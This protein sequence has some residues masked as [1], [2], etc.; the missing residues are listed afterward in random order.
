MTDSMLEEIT[1]GLCT[2]HGYAGDELTAAATAARAGE[3]PMLRDGANTSQ[4]VLELRVHGVGGAP[5]TEN[6]EAPAC[7]QVAGDRSAG[8]YRAWYPGR[9]V[10]KAAPRRE[11]Y[12][13]GKLNYQAATRALWLL[14]L[15]FA[16]LNVAHWA[17]PQSAAPALRPVGRAVLRL[18]AL[19]LTTAFVATSAFVLVDIVAWQA[20]ENR[21]L[22]SWLGWYERL[23]LGPRMTL[24]L[25]AVL[26]IVGGLVWLSVQTS[27]EYECWDAGVGAEDDPVW[28]LSG[29]AFWQ[30]E[31]PLVRQRYAHEI[32][33]AAVVVYVAAQ[34]H[35]SHP[36]LRYAFLIASAML[37]VV[38]AGVVA[39]GWTDRIR[40]AGEAPSTAD[41]VL[42]A[43]SVVCVL[44][45]VGVSITRLWW[46]PHHDEVAVPFDTTLQ[47]II[48]LVE[49]G[50]LVVLLLVV[51][52][53]RPA[54]Q[55]DVMGKGYN[56]ASLALLACLIA[57]IFG[58]AVT[59]SIANLL[60]QPTLSKPGTRTA[61][62]HNLFA[63]PTSVYAGGFGFFMVIVTAVCLTVTL[64]VLRSRLAARL[65]RGDG[66]GTVAAGYDRHGAA[67]EQVG[68][69]SGAVAR[70]WAT[71]ALTDYLPTSLCAVAVPSALALIGY[72]VFLL[73]G[74]GPSLLRM[75]AA[76]GSLAA[77][78]ATGVFVAQLRRALVDSTA[79]RRFGFFWDVVTFWPRACHPLGPPCYAERSIPELVTRIRRIVGGRAF[80][81][82][83][84]ALAHQLAE[85][86]GDPDPLLRERHSPV[87]LVGYSQ[88]SPIA[89]ATLAQLPP[90][91]R[92]QTALLTMAAPVR[93]LYG[94]AFPA[95]FGPAQLR[96]LERSLTADD[97]VVRWR[98][99][100][101]RSDYIGGWAL[102][103]PGDGQRP[104]GSVDAVIL[105]PPVLWVDADPT[106]PPTHTHLVWFPDPQ[107]R[108]AA[109]YLA[110]LLR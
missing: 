15:P 96:R 32:A 105:D 26:A 97:A 69:A 77:V 48:V 14:L 50:L 79:R 63:L 94:R 101:R 95:Y 13:W 74:P 2:G 39:S 51:A 18:I 88:G 90:D 99:L 78:L 49:F 106:P 91:V 44:F 23:A 110:G 72:Q 57:T 4:R 65:H 108:P 64:L 20:A 22:W 42:R 7:V 86:A 16:L 55:Q 41:T 30:G 109:A 36:V 10:N 1:L 53:Q 93:R 43:G 9:P 21:A 98:N 27:R 62:Q 46:R 31:R 35:G 24:A 25:G 58:G 68:G 29:H 66:P 28:P 81:P 56:A 85:L 83:D 6:L 19:S 73:H 8:F 76:F 33:A 104:D 75:I 45:A 61:E 11:A 71:A 12:C 84:P 70:S 67:G 100:V 40:H 17:L 34:P 80:G 89:V 82:E 54:R 37:G 59:L 87:L 102:A 52:A 5:P 107:T 103:D 38:A 47:V 60:G 3:V 92:A